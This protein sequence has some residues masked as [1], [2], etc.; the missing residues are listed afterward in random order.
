MSKAFQK[1]PLRLRDAQVLPADCRSNSEQHLP[2][3]PAAPLRGAEGLSPSPSRPPKRP[4]M[5]SIASRIE[6]PPVSAFRSQATGR[7]SVCSSRQHSRLL[8]LSDDVLLDHGS[9]LPAAIHHVLGPSS[10]DRQTQANIELLAL[11]RDQGWSRP[12]FMSTTRPKF[13]LS[14]RFLCQR[15]RCAGCFE[16]AVADEPTPTEARG[17]GPSNPAETE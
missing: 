13:R 15:A 17:W 14:R 6:T 1:R 16:L 4:S 11:N 2:S 12:G 5:V 8:H 7:A 9:C 3:V 10:Q